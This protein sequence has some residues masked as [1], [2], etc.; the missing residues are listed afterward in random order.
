VV[1]DPLS[2]QIFCFGKVFGRQPAN[3][4]ELEKSRRRDEAVA[5]FDTHTL[6][7]PS[8]AEWKW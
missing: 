6:R 8:Q 1:H 7:S 2:F 5:A 3:I 4:A